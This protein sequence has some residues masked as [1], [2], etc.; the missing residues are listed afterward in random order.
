MQHKVPKADPENPMLTSSHMNGN[1]VTDYK[2]DLTHGHW[3]T[4]DNALTRIFNYGKISITYLKLN[5]F[6][7]N[8]RLNIMME[9]V[10]FVILN[11]HEPINLKTTLLER[12]LTLF[13]AVQSIQ[14]C[15]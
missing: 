4:N 6:I 9:K 11:Q 7:S 2:D 15:S 13:C 5:N 12:I 8:K 1:Q 3:E 14:G 10:L